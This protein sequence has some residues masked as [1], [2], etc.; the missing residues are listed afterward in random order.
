M[1]FRKYD[2]NTI[3]VT[4]IMMMLTVTDLEWH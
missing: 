4:A 1:M 2:I 3:Y